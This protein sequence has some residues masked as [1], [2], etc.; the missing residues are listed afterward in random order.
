M[1]T[2]KA[3][4]HRPRSADLVIEAAWRYFHEDQNQNEIAEALGLSRG[5][6]VNYLAEAR[7]KQFVR[8]SLQPEVFREVQLARELRAAFGLAD[9]YVVPRHDGMTDR[10]ALKR[11]ARAAGDWL[12]GVLEPGDVLGVSW[13][14]TV[15]EVSLAVPGTRREV[16]VVQLVGSYPSPLGFAAETC[17]SNIAQRLDATCIN[18]NVP[19]LVSSEDLA[20]RLR[21]EPAIATQLAAAKNCNKTLFA[22]GTCTVDSH[23]VKLGVVSPDQLERLRERGAQAVIGG[24]FI[25]AEGRPVLM[26]V[27]RRMLSVELA[28]MKDK[29]M[30]ILVSV[31]ADRARAMAAA[32]RGRFASHL[33]T[34]SETARALLDLV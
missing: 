23:V 30:G 18:L 21:A 31:G 8:V 26:D 11:V 3:E 27:H 33:V 6:V 34:C 24:Q 4:L 22:A 7:A 19:L 32:I 17:S 20:E 28:Q 12:P 9:A 5:T 16:T 25:D 29:E 2:K 13:G 14:E 1:T 15:Y 10:E